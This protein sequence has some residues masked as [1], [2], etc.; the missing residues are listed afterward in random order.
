MKNWKLLN[1][2]EN[3]SVW[4]FVYDKLDFQPHNKNQKE[5][6]NIPHPNKCFDISMFYDDG[7]NEKLYN[8]LHATALFWFE[9]IS[10]GR[11]MYA[12]NWQQDS[13]SFRSNL[14]FE[15]NDFNEWLIPVFPN[16]DYL[17]FLNRELTNGIFADGINF[18]LSF[19]GENLLNTLEDK[20]SEILF[21]NCT[22][23]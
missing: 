9:R 5:I 2:I 19:W 3:K 8:D 21:K 4:S 20:P 15:K 16:G 14:P 6:L 12:L 22:S 1:E 18:K 17:F 23:K 13:F 11:E 7:F 10:N